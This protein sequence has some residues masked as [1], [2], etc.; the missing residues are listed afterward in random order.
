MSQPLANTL[1]AFYSKGPLTCQD[2]LNSLERSCL[3]P[4]G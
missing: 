1:M 4:C 2:A 3:V